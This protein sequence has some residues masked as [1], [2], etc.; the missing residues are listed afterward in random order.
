M[1]HPITTAT[2]ALAL[3]FLASAPA[4]SQSGD[5]TA[6]TQA[7][8]LASAPAERSAPRRASSLN[9]QALE[10]FVDGIAVATMEDHRIAGAVVAIVS[11]KQTLLL[12]GYGTADASTGEPVDPEKHLFRIA[13]IT[14]T[15]TAT[16]IMR[17]LE[18]GLIDLDSNVRQYLDGVDIDDHLGT[19]SIKD[20]LTHSAGFED[21][22]LGYYGPPPSS[23]EASIE[24]QLAAIAARQVREPGTVTSY[25]NYSFTLLGEVIARVSGQSYADYIR[26]EILLPL[27]M[28]NSDVRLKTTD[29]ISEEAWLAD[30]QRREARSHHWRA[31]WHEV[32][33][34]PASRDSVHAE[35]SMSAT[36]WD[37]ARY[38]K[39]HLNRGSYENVRILEA[40]TWERMSEPL[41]ANGPFTQANA[42]GFW[43]RDYAGYRALEH[44]GSINEFKSML[45]IIPELG[46]G[47]FVSTNTDSGS[48]LRSLARRV[49]EHFYPGTTAPQPSPPA[50]FAERAATYTGTYV[51]TRRNNTRFDRVFSAL[52]DSVT[53]ENTQDGYLVI[54]RG[55]SSRR[56]VEVEPEVFASLED[57]GRITFERNDAGDVRWMVPE[58]GSQAFEPIAF[59]ER[60]VT[61]VAPLG[62]TLLLSL[63]ILFWALFRRLRPAAEI[64]LGKHRVPVALLNLTAVGWLSVPAVFAVAI[65]GYLE[66]PVTLIS[67][68]PSPAFVVLAILLW[69]VAALT[70]ACVVMT[71]W[72]LTSSGDGRR[73]TTWAHCVAALCFGLTVISLYQWNVFRILES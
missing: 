45:T 37:M 3:C 64:G 73:G 15:F 70:A 62:L 53:V 36:G 55:D 52:L 26:N 27:G 72:A 54:S 4:H 18:Q 57:G 39:M 32:L 34:Y 30:L 61:L 42:H 47:F 29:G 19:I 44:G 21:R 23:E 25:S 24:A 20:L 71:P 68:Y 13:S 43:T 8:N 46:L 35:G 16:A 5:P 50:D 33:E 60:P 38:L 56:Y 2:L 48:K 11:P 49:V 69:A 22:F 17:L 65:R 28:V 41:F 40:D 58:S 7:P 59:F 10:A 1:R 63:V 51:G 67:P 9:P 6:G 31:G 66:S 14:K 12:K